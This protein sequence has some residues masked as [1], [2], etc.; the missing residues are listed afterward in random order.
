[1]RAAREN[2]GALGMRARFALRAGRE[3]EEDLLFSEREL[4]RAPGVSRPRDRLDACAAAHERRGCRIEETMRVRFE[5]RREVGWDG[6]ATAVP[7]HFAHRKLARE[8]ANV[9]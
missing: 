2:V 7:P 8:V 1:M 4:E 3:R 6:G 9:F 5:P